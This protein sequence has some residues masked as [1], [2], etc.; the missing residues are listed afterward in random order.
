LV[1]TLPYA[2]VF[3]DFFV[4]RDLF[5]NR[6]TT[7]ITPGIETEEYCTALHLAVLYNNTKVVKMIKEHPI[8]PDTWRNVI[9]RRIKC[10]PKKSDIEGWSVLTLAL[11]VGNKDILDILLSGKDITKN[12]VRIHLQ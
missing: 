11:L 2:D 10:A 8:Y 12:E 1:A 6:P 3:R 4:F 7:G 5:D 9:S